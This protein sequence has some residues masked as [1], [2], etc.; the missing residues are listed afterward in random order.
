[1]SHSALPGSRPA[2]RIAII[3]FAVASVALSFRLS[4]ATP[5]AALATLAALNMSRSEGLALVGLSWALNQAVGFLVLGYPHDAETY[6]WGVAIGVSA[7]AAFEVARF[8]I[9]R[10]ANLGRPAAIAA[11]LAAAFAAYEIVLFTATA[12]LPASD[13]AFSWHIIGE[14]ALVNALVLPGLLLAQRGL[15]MLG[16]DGAAARA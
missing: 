13:L 7:L 2:S 1:M 9:D 3:L 15:H 4:C 6:A 16:L 10:L 8:A 11:A 5:F 12:L 14:I